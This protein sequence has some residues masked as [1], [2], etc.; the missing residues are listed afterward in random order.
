MKQ[1]S[2]ARELVVTASNRKAFIVADDGTLQPLTIGQH[3]PAGAVVQIADD[4]ELQTEPV[5]PVRLAQH[6]RELPSGD[7]LP[8]ADASSDIDKLQKSILAGVDP[9]LNL[10]A[11]AAGGATAAATGDA[12]GSGNGGFIVI[13]RTSD[14][15]L[16][17]AGFDTSDETTTT[18][19]AVSQPA[20]AVSAAAN[21]APATS[22]IELTTNE[23]QPVTGSIVATDGDG[24]SLSYTLNGSPANGSV[25]LNA[26]GTF[27]YTPAGDFNGS[28]RFTVTISDGQGGT[29][30]STVT[31][32]VT[33]LND[34]P[35]SADLSLTTTEEQAVSGAIVATDLDGDS[36]S[37][38]MADAP[39]NG[40]VTLNGNGTFNYTPAGDFNGSDRF[41]VTIS[42][43][44]GGTTTST[45]TIGVAPQ[46]DAP[47]STDLS[48]NT[49]ED[50][51]VTGSIIATD[52][53][54]DSLSY[55]LNGEPTNGSVTLNEDGT[56]TY[57]PASNFNGSDSFSVT[58]SDGN[59]G[60]TT[61][62]VTIGVAPVTDIT[63]IS[64]SSTTAGQ[65]VE[66]G[67][68]TVYT[69]SVD[70]PVSGSPLTVTLSNGVIITIPVGGSSAESEPVVLRA[71]D[72][73]DQG[74]TRQDVSITKVDGGN[75]EQIV[76]GNTVSDTIVD[77]VDSTTVT[78]SA[79]VASVSEAGGAIVYTA[80]LSSASH[81]VTTVETTLGTITIADGEVKGV[82]TYT[83]PAGEDVYKEAGSISN[84]ITSATGGSF[85][86]LSPSTTPV[87]TPVLDTVNSTT[88]TLSADVASVS[89][90]G[91]AIVYT[92][93]LSSASHGVTTVETTLGTITIADGEV[94]GELTYTVPA[95]EDVYKDAGSISNA[96][97]SATGDSFEQL[98][99]N[100]TS[101]VTDMVFNPTSTNDIITIQEDMGN[102]SNRYI[103]QVDDFG[104]FNDQDTGDSLQ[105]IRIDSLPA[106][107]TFY[108]NGVAITSAMVSAPGGVTI[109][110]S[111]ISAENL[112]FD[113]ADNSDLDSSF[114]FSVSDG[115]N[116]SNTSYTTQLNI[117]ALADMPSLTVV[118]SSLGGHDLEPTGGVG[119]NGLI[120]N[121]YDNVSGLDYG[122]PNPKY[123]NAVSTETVE[124]VLE[125]TN[126]TSSTTVTDLGGKRIISV[127]DA[128]SAKGL[129]YLEA[130]HSYKFS[131]EQDDTFRLEIGG[132]AIVKNGFNSYGQYGG[133]Y[134]PTTSGYYSFEM[135]A[136]N[137]DGQGN[138]NVLVSVDGG[139]TKNLS[140]SNIPLFTGIDAVDKAG[141]QHGAQTVVGDGGY[142]AVEYNH[143]M[144]GTA[145]A[146]SPI[147]SALTDYLDGSES[148]SL[149]IGSIPV[150]AVLSDGIHSFTATTALGSVD[151]HSWNTST[152][153]LTPPAGFG[154]HIELTVTA[155]ASEGSN[156]SQAHV[157]TTLDV[158][159]DLSATYA[160]VST[161]IQGLS[162]EYYGHTGTGSMSNLDNLAEALSVI[163]SRQS[164]LGI[165]TINS[166]L[167]SN[168][169][170]NA[171]F[172]AT[173]LNYGGVTNKLG[174]NTSVTSGHLYDFLNM[175]GDAG[176][177]KA[178]TS[179]GTTN[180][181][182]VRMLGQAYFSGGDYSFQ[183]TANDGYVVYIDGV[184]ATQYTASVTSSS[185]ATTTSPAVSLAEGFHTVEVVYWD[186]GGSASF[187]MSYKESADSFWS[188]FDDSHLALFQAGKSP[189]LT[190][191]QDIVQDSDGD[192]VI[193]TGM[194]V[195]GTSGVDQITG[196]DGK[197]IIHG[198]AGADHLSGGGASDTLDGGL[199][200]D[201][202]V[203]GA[204]DDVLMGGLGN[205]TLTGGD[206]NDTF[207]WVKGDQ[208][209]T[210]TPAVDHVTDFDVAHDVLDISDL[211]EGY[212]TGTTAVLKQYLSVGSTTDGSTMIEVHNSTTTS[213]PVVQTI[214][215]DGMSYSELTGSGSSTASDVLN[216]LI[217]NHLLNIDK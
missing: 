49:N 24:D 56:F 36:V 107:G 213:S 151:I 110:V 89:E 162:G 80:T 138:I 73:Y 105:V 120:L 188:S 181:A 157:T 185:V 130:G 153:K 48:L 134:T 184:V 8:T 99:P 131:G 197:D 23:D 212:S 210:T 180:D 2:S 141:L 115:T 82:L 155:T 186:Q 146:L 165:G 38:T 91:G 58:V 13:D 93:T 189:T 215:L 81:G 25:I 149:V 143:G 158:T 192:W 111:D 33:P 140:T 123:S 86:Q 17:T 194:E 108:L 95:G 55:S 199:G 62:T 117:T 196:S 77:D 167:A 113:P 121:Y 203:G 5:A 35:T 183:V 40:T 84:A 29:T 129:I 92:A 171:T 11:T 57:T 96:I 104:S 144:A 32:G 59:G 178:T 200:N 54:G 42:D 21:T 4:G 166:T 208:G 118:A 187:A 74:N 68:A 14:S 211:L 176:S 209:T 204:G 87:V 9:T 135:F 71:D 174:T 34:A 18:T 31:I 102:T 133:T 70:Q 216:H 164:G 76:V 119:G 28:D 60:T 39:A 16:A 214:V 139:A 69:V 112:K 53:D 98:S 3:I 50:T 72:A 26:D 90:A 1:L 152:L 64:L 83:V 205:D 67:Q 106:N 207:K 132:S 15:T 127:N 10:E 22:D 147:T 126:P 142:Y 169:T 20:D 195:T 125:V 101:V 61:S 44:Q 137:G 94:K 156:N 173:E 193:R 47:T 103:L 198:G 122:N 27:T 7:G 128:F 79:D 6:H 19:T 182:V 172:V 168:P 160:D 150:G 78:L 159:V 52:L 116:W 43:G 30:T 88:V 202:L 114:K 177:L 37:Y 41:T 100:T 45:V 201:I 161:T 136:Y 175:G 12:S 85:E 148:L 51:P 66:E 145:I 206:G 75:F 179:F 190:S 109:K 65:P 170:T 46:N 97:T 163:T 124:S 154:G 191:L 63:T 217:D